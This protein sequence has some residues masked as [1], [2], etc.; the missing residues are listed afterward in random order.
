VSTP[1]LQT[2]ANANKDGRTT[3]IFS[4]VT[5][6]AG[7]GVG[8]SRDNPLGHPAHLAGI[9]TFQPVEKLFRVLHEIKPDLKRV[10][11]IWSSAEACSA[12]CLVK[13]R[14]ICRELGITLVE[15]TVDNSAGV[16]EAAQALTSRGVEAIWIGGDNTVE[17]ATDAV[18]GVAAAARIPVF[19]NNPEHS[20]LGALVT[21]G[22]NYYEVGRSAGT[23][24]AEILAGRDPATVRIED[25]TPPRLYLNRDALAATRGWQLPPAVLSRADAVW[26][27]GALDTAAAG[28]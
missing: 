5:D 11:T 19:T 7:A 18:I 10:G 1:G 4:I 15:T 22:A 13:A 9:G 3:H 20:P 26:H 24:A 8:I 16:R 6:P 25:V 23:L 27:D 21:L 28:R 14:T 17:V 12:A 2:V